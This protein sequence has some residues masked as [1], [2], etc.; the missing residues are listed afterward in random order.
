M[1]DAIAFFIVLLISLG[2]AGAAAAVANKKGRSGVGWFLLCLL[3]L[4]IIGLIIVA[5]LPSVTVAEP[6]PIDLKPKPAY[7]TVKWAE[8]VAADPELEIDRCRLGDGDA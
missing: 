7:D 2:I 1:D 8:L 5:L 4:G 6:T 3:L